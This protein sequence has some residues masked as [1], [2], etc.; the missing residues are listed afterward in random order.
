MNSATIILGTVSGGGAIMMGGLA[1]VI[2]IFLAVRWLVQK[3]G[4]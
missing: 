4:V 3:R 2:A 1:L